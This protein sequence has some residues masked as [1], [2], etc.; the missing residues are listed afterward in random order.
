MPFTRGLA[1]LFAVAIVLVGCDSGE[2]LE[3]VLW[4]DDATVE[5]TAHADILRVTE[6]QPPVGDLRAAT[7]ALEHAA[8]ESD[9]VRVEA[10]LCDWIQTF[11]P[12]FS[13]RPSGINDAP[14]R[15]PARRLSSQ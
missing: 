4:E 2:K 5:P 7:K 14:V 9:R 12:S 13:A 3:E 1:A 15:H 8:H 10:I 11:T 6:V